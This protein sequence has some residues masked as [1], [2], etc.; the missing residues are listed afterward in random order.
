MFNSVREFVTYY[1]L[2]IQIKSDEGQG[3]YKK[4]KSKNLIVSAKICESFQDQYNSRV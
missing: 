4:T 1:W 2:N 3:S